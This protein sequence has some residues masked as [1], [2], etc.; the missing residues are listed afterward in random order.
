LP[1]AVYREF[2]PALHYHHD[3]G[4]PEILG[5]QPRGQLK[6]GLQQTLTDGGTRLWKNGLIY[7]DDSKQWRTVVNMGKRMYRGC[8]FRRFPETKE[9]THGAT[10]TR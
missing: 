10:L 2:Y 6:P 7:I 4:P 9:T 1:K 5:L 3:L 8:F